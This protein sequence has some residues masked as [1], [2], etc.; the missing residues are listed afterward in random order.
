MSDFII[1]A[2]KNRVQANRVIG[3]ELEPILFAGEMTVSQ[4]SFWDIFKHKIE[5]VDNET[6]A[7]VIISDDKSFQVDSDISISDS[8]VNSVKEI[9]WLTEELIFPGASIASYPQIETPIPYTDP[10]FSS[11]ASSIKAIDTSEMEELSDGTSLQAFY[12][13]KTRD[14]GRR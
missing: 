7:L 10:S 11:V 9:G 1:Q 5:Y 14:Y 3:G 6:L 13:K 4:E 8:F 12:R 2:K